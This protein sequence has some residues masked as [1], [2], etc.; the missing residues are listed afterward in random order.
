M[1]VTSGVQPQLGWGVSGPPVAQNAVR[2]K[3]EQRNQINFP[4][5]SDPRK[6]RF[7]HGTRCRLGPSPPFSSLVVLCHRRSIL[8]ASDKTLSSTVLTPA[9][10]TPI[11]P[12]TYILGLELYSP[13][14]S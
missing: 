11:I 12:I 13:P 1:W 9:S 4:A 14:L 7:I 8:F 2:Y 3:S 6:C 5:N 10:L